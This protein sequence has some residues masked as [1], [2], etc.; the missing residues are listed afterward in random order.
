[1]NVQGRRQNEEKCPSKSPVLAD[2][3]APFSHS[4][5]FILHLCLNSPT[6]T[7]AGLTDNA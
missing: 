3:L 1:M 6:G 5:F 7:E 4:S 2:D